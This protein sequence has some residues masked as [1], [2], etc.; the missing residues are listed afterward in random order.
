MIMRLLQ[1]SLAILA[2]GVLSQ[3]G[4]ARGQGFVESVDPPVIH[5]GG[6]ARLTLHGHNLGPGLD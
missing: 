4:T 5:R 3:A 6:T 1:I 2:T